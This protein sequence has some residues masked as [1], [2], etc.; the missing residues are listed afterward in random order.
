LRQRLGFAVPRSTGAAG[1]RLR[2]A[3]DRADPPAHVD[4]PAGEPKVAG[5]SAPLPG[6]GKGPEPVAGPVAEAKAPA[7]AEASPADLIKAGSPAPRPSAEPIVLA[8]K[9]PDVPGSALG[10]PVRQEGAIRLPEDTDG[11]IEL[12]NGPGFLLTAVPGMPNAW[13]IATRTSS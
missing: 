10:S 8:F 4:A 11:R 6:L 5:V 1:D 2:P 12:L 3:P 9:P 7:K 13:E